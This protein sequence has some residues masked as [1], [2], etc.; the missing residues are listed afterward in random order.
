M[1]KKGGARPRAKLKYD[2]N[3]YTPDGLQSLSNEEV[4]Q[5]YSRLRAIAN[6]RVKR[7]AGSEWDFTETYK[8]NRFGFKSLKSIKSERELYHELS[9]L[10][11]FVNS[12]RSSIR[13]LQQQRSQTIQTLKDRGYKGINTSNFKNFI[14]FM[15]QAR[16]VNLD[17][18]Y[19]S[20]R[21]AE[22]FASFEQQDISQEDLFKA[23]EEFNKNRKELSK[24]QNQE[25]RN[26]DAVR[27][28]LNRR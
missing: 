25:F 15:E 10:A 24:I 6:K 17:K 16:I 28:R 20:E 27:E 12:K 13:G 22:E 4:R 23:I 11:R 14:D 2:S 21:V 19:T 7:L 9:D 1:A 18:Q 3:I 5:E 8:R 26:S